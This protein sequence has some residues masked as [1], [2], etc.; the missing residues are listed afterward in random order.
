MLDRMVELARE[1]KERT[2]AAIQSARW[3]S[4]IGF[5]MEMDYLYTPYVLEEKIK[6]LD[7]VLTVEIPEF[8]SK[9]GLE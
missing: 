6:V 1:E 2:T 4:R 9:N 7:Q 8:R 3:D 5:E